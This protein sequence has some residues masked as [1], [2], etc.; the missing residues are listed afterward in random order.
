M[1]IRRVESDR[2]VTIAAKLRR[3]SQARGRES[4]STAMCDCRRPQS[5][6][7]RQAGW[8]E[9]AEEKNKS[10]NKSK[11]MSNCSKF[12]WSNKS[13][14]MS[15]GESNTNNHKHGNGDGNGGKAQCATA[16]TCAGASRRKCTGYES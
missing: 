13:R 1:L 5:E 7:N 10:M 3:V 14:S 16:R 4:Q 6:K 15:K 9:L 11:S 12:N 8:G 2:G